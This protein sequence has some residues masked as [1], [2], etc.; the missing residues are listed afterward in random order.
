MPETTEL[1]SWPA[2]TPKD[3]FTLNTWDNQLSAVVG[4]AV[5][6]VLQLQLAPPFAVCFPELKQVDTAKGALPDGE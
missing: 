4:L 6:A 1:S 3:W 5:K 2:K